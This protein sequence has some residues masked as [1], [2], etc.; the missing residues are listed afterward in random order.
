MT[1]YKYF[2]KIASKNK[3]VIL[4]YTIIFFLMSL[5]AGT[6][7][8][9]REAKFTETKLNIGIIDNSN[10]ELSKG[11]KKY[12]KEKN[13]IIDTIDDEEYI[14]EQIF[15]ERVDAVLIIPNNFQEKVI[16]KEESIE[17][18]NDHRKIGSIQIQN[19]IN[20]FLLFANA[21][22]EDE[23]FDLADVNLALAEK[24]GVELVDNN[25]AKN[26]RVN[27]WFRN[28]YNFTSYVIIAMYIAIIGLV[29]ADFKDENIDSRMKISSKKFLNFNMEMYLGQLTIA[30][31]I[32][33]VFI[34]G[35]IVLKGKY[36]GEV[37]FG[38]YVI[39]I[40][41]FSFT[42]LCFTFFLNNFT[43]NKF[44]ISAMSTVL[45]LGT[46][47]ISGV[48][49]PQELLGEKTLALAKFF[50]SYYF[51][52]INE[53]AVSSFSDIKFELFMQLLFAVV[54]VLM[55][56]YFSKVKQKVA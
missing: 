10:D 52:K 15:L 16:N 51:V 31:I 46:S 42:I 7:A 19:Q 2:I 47:F 30:I 38:K 13:N 50:P 33:T 9:Q 8:N 3:G 45:S 41:I 32:T 48:M 12:L 22:Y 6:G 43:K 28:Y 29:M 21:S 4:G 23:K 44:V 25:T 11:L 5:L 54:F 34:L 40:I 24:T 37:G 39:N 36:I 27:E 18:Y 55:G 49:V 53:M 35:S 14:K 20:K 56:L 26:I 1:V 17:I